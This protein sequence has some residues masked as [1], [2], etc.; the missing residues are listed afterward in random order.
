M[1]RF[2]ALTLAVLGCSVLGCESS[3]PPCRERA[4]SSAQR[5]A[6]SIWCAPDQR[7]EVVEGWAIC[8][9]PP[10]APLSPSRVSP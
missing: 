3:A 10:L 8:R 1:S 9:C 7:L 2:L 5:E 6:G 4:G